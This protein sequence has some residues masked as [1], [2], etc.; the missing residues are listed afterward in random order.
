VFTYS[1]DFTSTTLVPMIDIK[2]PRISRFGG[3]VHCQIC[4]FQPN[5]LVIPPICERRIPS[6]PAFAESRQRAS[7]SCTFFDVLPRPSGYDGAILNKLREGIPF[8]SLGSE[9]KRKKP[10]IRR[11]RDPWFRRVLAWPVP[12]CLNGLPTEVEKQLKDE[13]RVIRKAEHLPVRRLSNVV[14]KSRR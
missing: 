3:D 2:E 11:S 9:L 14:S 1:I 5:I 8:E 4:C 6:D 7:F 12:N 10:C 13:W